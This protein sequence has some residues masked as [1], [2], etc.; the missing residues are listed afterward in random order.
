[1]VSK[2]SKKGFC[3]MRE[4][5][6]TLK[7]L[8]LL[9]WLSAFVTVLFHTWFSYKIQTVPLIVS[10]LA[11][12]G[13]GVCFFFLGKE[14]EE[15]RFF[16]KLLIPT[17]LIVIS[18]VMYGSQQ[19]TL[20]NAAFPFL[21]VLGLPFGMPFDYLFSICLSHGTAVSLYPFSMVLPWSF[22]A[23]AAIIGCK[24]NKKDLQ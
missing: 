19:D 11:M 10:F 2:N 16:L 14:E 23:I 18:A 9:F 22:F 4:R 5:N 12:L 1:M 3:E 17:A 8:L 13:S 24:T 6:F 15:P 20:R 21:C 7:V